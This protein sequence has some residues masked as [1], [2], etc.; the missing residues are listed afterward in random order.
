MPGRHV[1]SSAAAGEHYVIL[2]PVFSG[3]YIVRLKKANR[4]KGDGTYISYRLGL[5]PQGI[6]K[7]P[8]YTVMN[9]LMPEYLQGNTIKIFTVY[10]IEIINGAAMKNISHFC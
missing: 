4:H 6:C 2:L 9:I 3:Y 7:T 1:R 10:T 5:H 8:V